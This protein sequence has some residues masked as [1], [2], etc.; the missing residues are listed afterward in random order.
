MAS[1]G[2]QFKGIVLLTPLDGATFEVW[3]QRGSVAQNG[4]V[5]FNLAL[6]LPSSDL[7]NIGDGTTA[8]ARILAVESGDWPLTQDLL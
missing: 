1:I 4:D 8:C 3:L 6:P 7:C 2:L 5:E